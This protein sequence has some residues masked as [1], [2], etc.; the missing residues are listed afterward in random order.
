MNSI[1]SNGKSRF[2]EDK[3]YSRENFAYES[4]QAF[5]DP[6]I[7]AGEMGAHW[8]PKTDIIED[9]EGYSIFLEL[10]GYSKEFVEI[11]VNPVVL[12]VSGHRIEEAREDLQIHLRESSPG[13]FERAFKL[14]DNIDISAVEAKLEDGVLTIRLPKQKDK[15]PKKIQIR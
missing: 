15:R 10:P 5:D 14:P 13:S 3:M 1:F 11:S 9:A 6:Y 2:G 8:Q 4:V 7:K 12:K